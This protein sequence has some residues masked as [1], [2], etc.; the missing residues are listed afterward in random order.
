MIR[1]VA[2]PIDVAALL[3]A[4]SDPQCGAAVL[5]LGLTRQFTGDRETVRLAYESYEPMARAEMERLASEARDRWPIV[6]CGIIHRLGVVPLSEASVAIAVSSPHRADA[7]KAGQW[8][9]DRLK[10]TVPIWKQ[11][12]WADGSTEWVH[13]EAAP[14]PPP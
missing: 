8:L 9:I 12:H 13:P 7:F 14:P 5:F 4:V 2:E 10:E 6:G 1:L 3:D 11:E